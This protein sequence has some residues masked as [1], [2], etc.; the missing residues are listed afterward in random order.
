MKLGMYIMAR[1]PISTAYFINPFHHS[2]CLYVCP[3]LVTRQWLGKKVTAAKH[4]HTIIELL[5]A[6]FSMRSISHPRKAENDFLRRN[7]C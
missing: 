6:S 4:T 1:E 2:V 7:A 5:G 3:H